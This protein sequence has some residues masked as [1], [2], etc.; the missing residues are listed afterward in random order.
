MLS[1]FSK[2]V[3]DDS[4]GE[5]SI[6][7]KIVQKSRA[8]VDIRKDMKEPWLNNALVDRIGCSDKNQW[9]YA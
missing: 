1:H 6:C 5:A 8:Q 3:G 4:E 9:I 2:L 7:A